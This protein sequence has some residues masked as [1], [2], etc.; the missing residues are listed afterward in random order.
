MGSVVS[1]EVSSGT[2]EDAFVELLAER[3]NERSGDT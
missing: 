3:R 2:L 1:F